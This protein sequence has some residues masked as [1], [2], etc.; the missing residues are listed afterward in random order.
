[1]LENLSI[2]L[3]GAGGLS[4]RF[5]AEL[6]VSRG[7]RLWLS[8]RSADAPWPEAVAAA[9]K[10]GRA[11]D[12]RPRD[13]AALLDDILKDRTLDLVITAPGVPL[14]SPLLQAV[15]QRGLSLR[16]ENDFAY[17]MLRKICSRNG[18]AMP[19]VVAVTGTDGKSTTTA[20]IAHLIAGACGARALP[21]GNFGRPLSQI[22]VEQD[23]ADVLV[24]ECSS[25][26]LELVESF[27]PDVAAILNL[28][29]DHLDRYANL[30]AYLRAKLNVLQNMRAPGVFLAPDWIV[31][32]ARRVPAGTPTPELRTVPTIAETGMPDRLTYRDADLTAAT[33]F[34][35]PGVHNQENLRFA[36]AVLEALEAQGDSRLVVDR[37]KLVEAVRSFSGLA[38][39]M[40]VV[41]DRDGVLFI[42]DSKATTVQAV[43]A[44]LASFSGAAERVFLLC[45]GRGKGA[46]F[47][48]LGG[49]ANVTLFPFGEA[50]PAIAAAVRDVAL[51]S[52]APFADL[53]TAFE[54]ARK[55]AEIYVKN[56]G[57]RSILLLSPACASFDAFRS[58]TER[59]EFFR[60]LVHAALS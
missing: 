48:A 56:E 40:E 27:A 41:A 52:K 45:G 15:Q 11:V 7:A 26:Q 14:A 6:C 12:L 42:N 21:C 60:G 43:G 31:E 24:V 29:D 17:E 25:F 54:A 18:R 9:I 32:R 38:H 1:M 37:T 30:D 3:C 39:R 20:L 34:P 5:A 13:D 58:Y 23:D 19:R 49:R 47:G 10:D 55:A 2:L 28:A 33:E 46:D 36:L 50:G 16:G 51:D 35:L 44:A 59:G 53:K 4:G 8:D 22:V 57:G